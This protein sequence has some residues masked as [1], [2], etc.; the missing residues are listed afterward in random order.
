M[1][2]EANIARLQTQANIKDCATKELSRIEEQI[3]E[4]ISN[5]KFSIYGDG[6]LQHETKSRLEELGYEVKAG[7]KYNEPYYSI[8]WE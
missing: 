3:H 7:Q 5:G 2:L 4:A 1:I 8:S 6:N